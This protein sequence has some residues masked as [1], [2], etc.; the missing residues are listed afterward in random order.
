M[1]GITIE[2]NVFYSIFF[3]FFLFYVK[4][5]NVKFNIKIVPKL[6]YFAS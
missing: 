2:W 1:K 3:L 6:K 5:K 4:M